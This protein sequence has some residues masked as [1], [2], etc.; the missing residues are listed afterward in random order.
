ME[1]NQGKSG[2]HIHLR[3]LLCARSPAAAPQGPAPGVM[4]TG[5][6]LTHRGPT[7]HP[8]G[9]ARVPA[10]AFRK[11]RVINTHTCGPSKRFAP[12]NDTA[13]CNA[14][15]LM[16]RFIIETLGPGS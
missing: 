4:G 16:G 6:S 1:G 14:S 13:V 5:R 11:Q 15:V 12:S 10:P 2:L 7:G 9:P 8:P 3:G